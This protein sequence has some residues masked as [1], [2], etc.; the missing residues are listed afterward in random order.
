VTARRT[1]AIRHNESKGARTMSDEPTGP[2]PKAGDQWGDVLKGLDEFGD[3]VSRWVRASVNDPKNRERAEELKSHLGTATEKVSSAVQD[4]SQTEA[5]QSMRNAAGQAGEAF[6][7]AGEKF[8]SEVAPSLA[9]MF[10]SA[11]AGLSEAAAKI[12]ARGAAVE[13]SPSG[14]PAERTATEAESSPAEPKE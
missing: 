7:Q 11:A 5:G 8:S 14:E 4:V 12:E 1:S 2:G 13:E 3:A 10:R 6:K 9:D